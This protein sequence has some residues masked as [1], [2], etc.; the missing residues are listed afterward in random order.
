MKKLIFIAPSYFPHSGGVENHIKNI[1][2]QFVGRGYAVS[3]LVRYFPDFPVSQK[4][5]GVQVIRLPR[6][7]RWPF[8]LLWFFR[9]REVFQN[10][11]AI[12]SHD[13]YLPGLRKLLP[14]IR[15]IHTFHGYEGYP[16]SEKAVRA[17]RRIRKEVDFCVCVGGFIEKWYGTKCDFVTYGAVKKPNVEESSNPK[18]ETI[19][20]GR[21]EPDTGFQNY[22][23][24][25]RDIS[26]GEKTSLLVVGDG[27]LRD[28]GENFVQKNSLNVKFEGSVTEVTEYLQSAKV[29][30][31][32]GYLGILEAALAK[33][34]IIAF[35][36]TP[37]KDDYLAIHP[38]AKNFFI[39]KSNQEIVK[40]FQK[41]KSIDQQKLNEFASWAER[42]T[43]ASI[44]D[45]YEEEYKRKQ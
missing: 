35:S 16:I 42:Q 10:I 43:W 17:R 14:N 39:A 24:A 33:K 45:K 40:F 5:E 27:S 34:P 31:V 11:Q 22:L 18:F 41:A 12:H 4:V 2:E 28:W 21:L 6:F 32:S 44:A 37:I 20:F 29:A 7:T 15:W 1:A 25:F 3:V 8:F 38:M 23:E 30:F 19:F 36:G 9:N 26:G 13:V